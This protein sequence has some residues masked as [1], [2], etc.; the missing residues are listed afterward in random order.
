MPYFDFHCHPGL[1]PLFSDL[2]N[3]PSP[4]DNITAT[5]EVPILKS[6]G[7]NLLFNEVLNSQS[8]L[9]QLAKEVKLIGVVL[10]APEQNM[11]K[12][13]GERKA[14]QSSRISFL[15]LNRIQFI[16]SGN[17]SFTIIKEELERLTTTVS[18]NGASLKIISKS[19]DFDERKPNTVYG[20][21]IIEGLH[22]FF[23]DPNAPDAKQQFE[24]NF[25]SFTN[26]HT[27]FAVNLCHIQLN[28]FCNHAFGIQ[29]F[30]NE[31]FYPLGNGI[32]EWGRQMVEKL[33][34]KN[35]LI[36]VK[37]MSLKSRRQFYEIMK[38]NKGKYSQPLICTH[39]G[40]TGLSI[41]DRV[42]YLR[43]KIQDVG[44]V[45]RVVYLKPRS[46]HLQ[47]TYF[48]CSSINLYDED[49][50]EIL[51]SGGLIGLSFD[52]RIIGFAN[53][54]F[55]R[56]ATIPHE[57][58]FI[59]RSEASFFLGPSPLLLPVYNGDD[60]WSSEDFENLD[61][62]MNEEVHL[63][64]FFN[65]AFHIL[66][67]AKRKGLSAK[68]ASKQICLGTDFDGLINAIDSC[69]TAADLPAFKQKAISRL[70]KLFRKAKLDREGIIVTEFVE[71]LFY[72]NG[73]N[74]VLNRLSNKTI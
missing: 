46:K 3:A 35:I 12:S 67:V 70:P 26:D 51:R 25:K 60:I 42:K 64:F 57:A 41:N 44:D 19:T 58:E 59:G 22:C 9:T 32:T 50:E 29:F 36:D 63:E 13:L 18:N 74:F 10:H 56:N 40:V 39:A 6:I 72:R 49:I 45:Y 23:N 28:P 71:D 21:I 43:E 34:A 1:K 62:A 11:A 8:S 7:I 30:K 65:Q 5:I 31:Y 66:D 73:R 69:K 20:V 54:N 53:E 17:H 33:K 68:Q 47:N 2:N 24:A 37:H 4:W 15:N 61:P 14:I 48:N 52:Q 38:D 27:V 55:L 16:A